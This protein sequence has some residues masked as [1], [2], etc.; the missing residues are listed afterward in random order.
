MI[1]MVASISLY[2]LGVML[3]CQRLLIILGNICFLIG[4][5]MFIGLYGTIGFLV[6]K[7][8]NI[9]IKEK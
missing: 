9:F 3:F 6:K 1:L 7:G 4:M 2:T 5:Y 8:I